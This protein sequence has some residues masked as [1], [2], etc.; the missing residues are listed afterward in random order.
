MNE[1]KYNQ[2]VV[3]VG[4]NFSYPEDCTFSNYDRW[5]RLL[6]VWISYAGDISE[7]EGCLDSVEQRC[8]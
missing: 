1:R 4:I 7:D 2:L 3:Y 8:A 5:A 6:Q